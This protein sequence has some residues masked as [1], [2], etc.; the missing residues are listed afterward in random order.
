MPL[1]G[2]GGGQNE[3]ELKFELK[4]G[5]IAPC[6][7][8]HKHNLFLFVLT[9][10][11][12]YEDGDGQALRDTLNRFNSLNFRRLSR[13]GLLHIYNIQFWSLY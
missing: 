13:G 12:S 4:F 2:G 10:V 11:D 6:N 3:V 9:D 8:R 5:E 1:E 7:L